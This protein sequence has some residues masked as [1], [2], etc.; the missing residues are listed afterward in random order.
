ME[1]CY[2]C[3]ACLAQEDSPAPPEAVKVLARIRARKLAT[4]RTLSYIAQVTFPPPRLGALGR[5]S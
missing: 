5:S 1:F 2:S 4:T 3:V